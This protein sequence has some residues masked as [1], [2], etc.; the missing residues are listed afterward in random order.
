MKFLFTGNSHF[1]NKGC[2]AISR[3]TVE[4]LSNRFPGAK[5][6]ICSIGYNVYEDA[7]NESNPL[8]EHRIPVQEIKKYSLTW[9]KYYVLLR[10]FPSFAKKYIT[11]VEHQAMLEADCGFHLG[12]DMYSLE[13][14][15]PNRLVTLDSEMINTGKPF[16]H[17]GSSIGPF[18]KDPEF[19]NLMKSHLKRYSLICARES[20]TVAYLDSIGV[21]ENV[22]LVADPAFVMKPQKPD[23]SEELY[24]FIEKKPIGLNLNPL[25][26]RYSGHSDWDS[27]A[28]SCIEALI[29]SDLP[30]LLLVPHV[31]TQGQDDYEFM[32]KITQNISA[33]KNRIMIAPPRLTA[34]EYKWII[35]NL[36]SFIGARTHTTIASLST[37]IPTISIGYSQKSRGINK[38]IF[39][40]LEWLIPVDQLTPDNLRTI[41][42]RIVSQ[43]D[44]VKKHLNN[45][46][47]GFIER[48]YSAGD[49]VAKLLE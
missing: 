33:D 11:H 42:K 3:G 8:I 29:N 9:F 19:E 13:Y 14:G 35:S 28:T 17:W 20:E 23:L 12:G 5:F 27:H 44:E 32:H 39:G 15:K 38:D 47:P 24:S 10:Q 31:F 46:I 48:A 49:L 2:E 16:V 43:Q 40:H 45:V 1:L 34:P 7:L 6:I 26:G 18:T 30:P 37:C 36:Q 4:I 21:S 41:T 25:V 22:R